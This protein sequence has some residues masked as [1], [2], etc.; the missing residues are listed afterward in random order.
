MS[1]KWN[2]LCLSLV[3]ISFGTWCQPLQ[4]SESGRPFPDFGFAPDQY[5]K[6]LFRLR[7]D[8]P[9]KMPAKEEIPAWFQADMPEPQWRAYYKEH[10]RDYLLD[11]RNYCFEG[12]I[13]H[14]WRVEENTVRDWYHM[15]WQHWGRLAREGLRGLTKEAPVRP[16]Q[17]GPQQS[18]GGQAYA[19]AFYNNFAG[20]LIGKVWQNPDAPNI[21]A[22]AE[23]NGFPH[24]TVVFKLLFVDIASDTVTCLT[25]PLTWKA[26]IT[27]SL[28]SDDRSNREVH[29]MQMDIMVKDDRAE[30]GWLFGTYQ[31]NGALQNSNPWENLVPV[32]LQWGN[33][34]DVVRDEYTNPQPSAT[35]INPNIK[36][37]VIN[38]DTNELPATHL[39]WNG[40]LNGPLDNP[41]SACMSCHM[42]AH[43]PYD[44]DLIA[45]M[46]VKGKS[47]QPGSTEWMQWFKNLSCMEP[48][49]SGAT[50]TDGSLQMSMSLKNF[51]D[52][53]K[54]RGGKFSTKVAAP[55]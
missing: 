35:R 5:D 40:R 44:G 7:Q 31:Y 43:F 12:N 4:G 50:P 3:V 30:T 1:H 33:D 8:Y 46:F 39:G 54:N 47:Y 13:E 42:T 49:I 25:N 51:Y 2:C 36:E 37:S 17:L 22:I 20:H 26:Y 23:H 27:S 24:G 55:Q 15:P 28:G 19:I 6:P 32:G 53:Q 10:W 18:A 41:R 52:W 9:T 16:R 34:P 14:E 29:L 48:F 21:A 45:P 11:I 38:P